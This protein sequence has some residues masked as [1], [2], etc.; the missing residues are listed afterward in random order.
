MSSWSSDQETT[1]PLCIRCGRVTRAPK[2]V[3]WVCRHKEAQSGVRI[4]AERP[5]KGAK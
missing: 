5:V 1:W 4:V 3:C 2:S